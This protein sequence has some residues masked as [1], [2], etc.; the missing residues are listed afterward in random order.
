MQSTGQTVTHDLSFTPMH[1]SAIMK[2]IATSE[3][4]R[5]SRSRER[6]IASTFAALSV[7]SAKQSPCSTEIASAQ[8]ACLAMTLFHHV[9]RA[10]LHLLKFLNWHSARNEREGE[11]FQAAKL[12]GQTYFA[13]SKLWIANQV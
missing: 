9:H 10:V 12:R 2:A 6:V 4:F 3:N 11:N 8:R 1:G 13:V 5:L 7:N